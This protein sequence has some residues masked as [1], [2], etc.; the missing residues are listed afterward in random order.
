[1]L[2]I[3][4]NFFYNRIG[5]IYS[6]LSIFLKYK[7]NTVLFDSFGGQYN[8][9]PKYISEKLHELYPDID[10]V[11][12]RSDKSKT[13]PPS[14]VKVIEYGSKDYFEY[15]YTSRVVID[16]HSG[17]RTLYAKKDHFFKNILYSFISRKRKGQLCISTWHGTPLKKIGLDMPGGD[18]LRCHMNNDYMISGCGLTERVLTSTNRI[19]VVV[20]TY[21]TPRNDLL[22]DLN[23]DSSDIRKKLKLPLNKKIVLYAPT[24]RNSLIF[25][26]IKQMNELD[27]EKLL[28]ILNLK[29]GGDWCFVYRLHNKVQDRIDLSKIKNKFPNIDYFNGNIDDDMAPYLQVSDILITDYSSSLFDFALTLKPCFIYAPDLEHY[30][31]DERG[32][33][34]DIKDLPYPISETSEELYSSILNIDLDNMKNNIKLFLKDINNYEKGTA[35]LS[36]VN[37]ILNFLRTKKK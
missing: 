33:Y 36:I 22:L 6:F 37:D 17:L 12:T 26:G 29:F 31:N 23:I 27:F 35:S 13:L 28:N 2:K 16:N 5:I 1:M 15:L 32:F 11:W 19:K 9:N 18:S 14:Y 3:M 7:N 10:I 21:G 34:F 20:K 25:S 8:D 4:M 30:K 24:F